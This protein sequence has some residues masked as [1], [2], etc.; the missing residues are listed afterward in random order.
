MRSIAEDGNVVA[1]ATRGP[2]SGGT[3]EVEAIFFNEQV[4]L[5]T[6]IVEKFAGLGAVFIGLKYFR[7]GALEAP[8]DKERCPVDDFSDGSSIDAFEEAHAQLLRGA[9]NGGV[10]V[11]W[12]LA[13]F[14][15][16]DDNRGLFLFVGFS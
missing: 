12:T 6:G 4:E 14:V 9:R 2:Q 11:Q 13:C 1:R 7:E 3:A 5:A 8:G 10:D 16:R 15:E